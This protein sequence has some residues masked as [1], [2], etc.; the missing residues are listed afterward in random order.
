MHTATAMNA[1]V[2]TADG[3]YDGVRW[4]QFGMNTETYEEFKSFPRVMAYDGLTFQ[5]MSWNSDNHTVTYKHVGK[6]ATAYEG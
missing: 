5:K 4:I 2:P 6:V 3:I 1:F